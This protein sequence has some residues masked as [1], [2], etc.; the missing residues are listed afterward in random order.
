M[1]WVIGDVH[2][3]L[4]PLRAMI[5]AVTRR[6][7]SPRLLFVG[8]YVNRGPDSRGVVDLLLGL[9]DASFVRGNHDDVFDLVLH[10]D[11]Y[12]PSAVPDAVSAFVWFMNHG[13]ATTFSSYGVDFADLEHAVRKPSPQILEGVTAAVPEAHR[14]FFRSLPAVIEEDDLFVAHAM[15]PIDESDDWPGVEA[16][17]R[18]T[19]RLRH[20][21]LWGRYRDA[22]VLARKHWHR[23]GYFGHTPVET[24][25]R[26]VTG[27]RN[28]PVLGPG[29]VLLDTAAALTP[30]GR[31]SAVCVESGE[32]VQVDRAGA[33]L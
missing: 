17:L 9:P 10:G 2:G 25:G 32:V 5:D 11:C 13:L 33:I 14:R 8:D 28:V 16:T 3:M 15:W 19:R 27:G 4:R 6:D 12:D 22:E 24:F 26:R 20:V 23:T 29:I 30:D 18:A 7:P 31:L 1:R 21:V